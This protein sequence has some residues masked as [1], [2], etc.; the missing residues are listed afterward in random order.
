MKIKLHDLEWKKVDVVKEFQ[1]LCDKWEERAG[2]S[3]RS[4]AAYMFAN[5]EDVVREKAAIKNRAFTY[6]SDELK[7]IFIRAGFSTTAVA[8]NLEYVHNQY[9]L[10]VVLLLKEVYFCI[11]K[12]VGDE[13]TY[14]STSRLIPFNDWKRIEYYYIHF[15]NLLTF[16]VENGD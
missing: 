10:R 5:A 16:E 11:M 13:R 8:K 15:R 2:D 3:N 6:D 1:L 7:A 9:T 4:N 14:T 12:Q